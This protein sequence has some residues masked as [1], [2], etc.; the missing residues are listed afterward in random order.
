MSGAEL[1]LCIGLAR[2]RWTLGAGPSCMDVQG[3]RI[4][5]SMIVRCRRL[6]GRQKLDARDVT[7]A[8]VYACPRHLDARGVRTSQAVLCAC[9]SEAVCG[10]RNPSL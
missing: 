1:K 3:Q 8:W 9:S 4:D 6:V 10:V 7:S 2:F 5:A